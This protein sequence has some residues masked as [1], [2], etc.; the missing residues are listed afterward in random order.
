MT[1]NIQTRLPKSPNVATEIFLIMYQET[2]QKEQKLE[3]TRTSTKHVKQP[4]SLSG[5]GAKI[6]KIK[7]LS[8]IGNSIQDRSQ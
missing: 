3:T 4:H 6:Y 5:Q 7:S 8:L 2:M 1:I